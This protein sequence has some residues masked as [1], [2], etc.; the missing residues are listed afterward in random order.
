MIATFLIFHTGLKNHDL[1]ELAFQI[2]ETDQ[3]IV[4]G[5]RNKHK[6]WHHEDYDPFGWL[7]HHEKRKW[8]EIKNGMN[9]V[10]RSQILFPFLH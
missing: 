1:L 6:K 9:E 7:H 2:G 3:R 5:F 8:G 10:D 4:Y